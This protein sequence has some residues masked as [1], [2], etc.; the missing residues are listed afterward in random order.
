MWCNV[1][2]SAAGQKENSSDIGIL[3]QNFTQLPAEGKSLLKNYLQNL[4][5]LQ[6]AMRGAISIDNIRG[7]LKGKNCL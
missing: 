1:G 6:N 7:S 5:S 4:V 2:N 3:E